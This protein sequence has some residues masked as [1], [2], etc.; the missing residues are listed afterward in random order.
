[1]TREFILLPEFEKQWTR[2]GLNDEH[3]KAF[4][5]FLC[6][7]PAYG[8]MIEGTGGLRKI[9]WRLPGIGKRGGV[10]VLYVD[11]ATYE[12]TYLVTVFKKNQKVSLSQKEKQLIK[13]TMSTLKQEAGRKHI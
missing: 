2:L 6:V 11:F 8:D 10:R 13:R 4:Q 1:M 12:K 7:Q 5:E 9:R 3:L